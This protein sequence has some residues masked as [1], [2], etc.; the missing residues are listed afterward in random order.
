MGQQINQ[1]KHYLIWITQTGSHNKNSQ[2]YPPYVHNDEHY[3]H[4]SLFDY[5][6]IS[7][8]CLWWLGEG[9]YLYDHVLLL[10]SGLT[11]MSVTSALLE[12]HTEHK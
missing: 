7:S 9:F 4:S 8:Q 2:C 11:K 6:I 10:S 12:F 3:I 1:N 5:V